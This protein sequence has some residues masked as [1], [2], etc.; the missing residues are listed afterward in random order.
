MFDRL[1]HVSQK[2]TDTFAQTQRQKPLTSNRIA[3]SHQSQS[4]APIVARFSTSSVSFVPSVRPLTVKTPTSTPV[5]RSGLSFNRLFKS[6][7]IA[8][9]SL[10]FIHSQTRPS[11]DLMCSVNP[12]DD[13]LTYQHVFSDSSDT[14]V[15]K[16]I[17]AALCYNTLSQNI[18][19]VF[20]P[21]DKSLSDCY[22]FGNSTGSSDPA[23]ANRTI[24]D[25]SVQM[26]EYGSPNSIRCASWMTY[27]SGQCGFKNDGTVIEKDPDVSE[28]SQRNTYPSSEALIYFTLLVASLVVRQGI[29]YGLK[30]SQTTNFDEFIKEIKRLTANCI[31]VNDT[32]NRQKNFGPIISNFQQ[33]VEQEEPLLVPLL[34]EIILNAALVG[35]SSKSKSVIDVSELT[36]QNMLVAELLFSVL[37]FIPMCFRSDKN[38]MAFFQRF[39]SFYQ[40]YNNNHESPL[41]HQFKH[42]LNAKLLEIKDQSEKWTADTDW[43]KKLQDEQLADTILQSA[44]CRDA[45]NQLAQ[46]VSY[47]A[48]YPIIMLISD[49]ASQ[50]NLWWMMFISGVIR[51]SAQFGGHSLKPKSIPLKVFEFYSS[52]FSE[53]SSDS[54]ANSIDLGSPTGSTNSDENSQDGGSERDSAADTD[55]EMGQ[56]GASRPT[57]K[58]N[59]QASENKPFIDF[60]VL[61][62]RSSVRNDTARVTDTS[63]KP[64]HK[65]SENN[66]IDFS[67]INM[68]T[69]ESRGRPV[70]ST[71]STN[72]RE[73]SSAPSR[74]QRRFQISSPLPK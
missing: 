43:V 55:I 34:T 35:V 26:M 27:F 46:M 21:P 14:S 33:I 39:T 8:L 41:K 10:P 30:R 71:K 13:D 23:V 49:S 69:K 7:A 42:D 65:K 36:Y 51:R 31:N 6:A 57:D 17:G 61:D 9:L 45:F 52:L 18:S 40:G 5:Y 59:Q 67:A 12:C 44:P 20:G 3:P 66:R 32:T 22:Y 37:F 70:S 28:K 58:S 63:N 29:D 4:V 11:D 16:Q 53:S 1:P 2:S 73:S 25:L 15:A 19:N 68:A 54:S 24:T 38:K 62:R 50:S 56:Q 74:L 72:R 48:I 64:A 60:S 47:I